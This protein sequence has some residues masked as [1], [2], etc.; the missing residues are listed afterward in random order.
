[1]IDNELYNTH[2]ITKVKRRG[3]LNR[4]LEWIMIGTSLALGVM[5]TWTWDGTNLKNETTYI[6]RHIGKKK[7]IKS[8]NFAGLATIYF[9]RVGFQ[10]WTVPTDWNNAS[11]TISVIG[12][13]GAAGGTGAA[14]GGGGY[15]AVNNFSLA[16]GATTW[17]LVGRGSV[18]FEAGGTSYFC[19]ANRAPTNSGEGCLATGGGAG[20]APSVGGIGG[21]TVLSGGGIGDVIH[22]GGYGGGSNLVS[23]GGGGGGAAGPHGNGVD[24]QNGIGTPSGGSGGAGDA[25]YGGAGGISTPA[26]GLIN[27]GLNGPNMGSGGGGAEC[28]IIGVVGKG[29]L[30]G[31]GGGGNGG[32]IGAQG[33]VKISYTPAY[34]PP[35]P[36]NTVANTPAVSGNGGGLCECVMPVYNPGNEDTGSAKHAQYYWAYGS[37]SDTWSG[38]AH[39]DS[40]YNKLQSLASDDD[41][42]D[43]DN[44]YDTPTSWAVTN[45]QENPFNDY[46]RVWKSRSNEW[47]EDSGQ[48]S[49][50]ARH[51]VTMANSLCLPASEPALGYVT[52][53]TNLLYMNEQTSGYRLTY[54]NATGYFQ[55]GDIIAQDI[56]SNT[57][58]YGTLFQMDPNY[59]WLNIPIGAFISGLPVYNATD[60]TINAFVLDSVHIAE[61]YSTNVFIGHSRY[62]SKS[63]VLA[64]G[65]DAED[66][67]VYMSV[68][69]PANANFKVYGKVINSYDPT[70]YQDRIW[71]L[72]H[73]SNNTSSSFSSLTNLNDFVNVEYHFPTSQLLYGPISGCSC[74]TSS[75][76]ISVPSSNAFT[77]GVRVYLSDT[78]SGAFNVRT[79]GFLPDNQTI[80][81]LSLPSF[82]SS[83]VSVGI[84]P[85]LED[86]MAAFL[87]DQNNNSMRYVTKDDIYFDSFKQFA[88]KVVPISDSPVIVPRATNL[89]VLALQV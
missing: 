21:N 84:I 3:K 35:I 13:G 51:R 33:I 39:Y 78:V 87:Y 75:F 83:N 61:K 41:T 26:Y 6:E 73:E 48:R 68:Y 76:Q 86:D 67:T 57:T 14:G 20:S 49:V 65:Q 11:N 69:R 70:L 46:P 4:F 37:W 82:A 2:F 77:T 72:L 88:V 34:V 19:I 81:V 43:Y 59:I 63:T 58:T 80:Q 16:P 71:S 85:G 47:L 28:T 24:G 8:E 74:N 44:Q 89:R 23:Y 17:V 12:G 15:A 79:V 55:H 50:W 18:L 5:Q 56:N 27:D 45:E 64:T 1:M 52:C 32:S 66:L 54:S 9:T 29:G 36:A 22:F 31:G 53:T 38:P 62:I 7:T 25:G 30:Y 42:S 60:P 10:T 40:N